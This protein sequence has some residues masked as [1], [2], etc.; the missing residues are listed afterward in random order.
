MEITEKDAA[1]AAKRI[2]EQ[3]G[4]KTAYV[5]QFRSLLDRYKEGYV[6]KAKTQ[7]EP[8]ETEMLIEGVFAMIEAWELEKMAY[9]DKKFD[10]IRAQVL[11]QHHA[12]NYIRRLHQGYKEQPIKIRQ[13][14]EPYWLYQRKAWES[15]A[16]YSQEESAGYQNGVLRQVA[17]EA[18]ASQAG[19]K[20]VSLDNPDIDA[21]Q[22]IDTVIKKN[23]FWVA[24]QI[25]PL[26]ESAPQYKHAGFSLKAINPDQQIFNYEYLEDFRVGVNDFAEERGVSRD[27]I[28]GV[29]L[30]IVPEAWVFNRISGEPSDKFKSNLAAALQ[31]LNPPM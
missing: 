22:K 25:K 3:T 31:T 9:G 2:H 26:N 14:L 10:R 23:G 12:V 24:L 21:I 16:G 19:W 29:L 7:G 20:V 15:I 4:I 5:D 18:T 30:R 8:P 28:Q 17:V 6:N 13:I 27:R 11:A 1:K